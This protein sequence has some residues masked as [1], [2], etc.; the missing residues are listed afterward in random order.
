MRPIVLKVG[1]LAGA[2]V[3]NIGL[4]QS[5]AGAGWLALNGTLGTATANSIALSQSLAGAGAVL[6]NGAVGDKPIVQ[7][8]GK[9][10]I[11]ATPSRIYITSAGND[12]GIT[13]AVVGLTANGTG[14]SETITGANVG[15]AVSA[16]LYTTIISITASGATAAAITVGS[17]G[18]ATLD[19]PRRVLITTASAISFTIS[20]TNVSGDPISETV[21]NSGASVASVLDYATV[22]SISNSAAGTTITVGTNGVAASPWA[23][24]DEYTFA[25]VGLQCTVSGTANYTVQQSYDDPNL[26]V[27]PAAPSAMT[28]LSSNDTVVV[29][30]SASQVSLFASPPLWVRTLLNSGSGSVTTTVAQYASP[31][32]GPS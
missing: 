8:S 22:T 24:M 10:A 6:L 29:A 4:S 1:P 7:T 18:A 19:L 16:N 30:A 28:W 13:F 11:L 23:R 15:V 12:G 14:V 25:P 27:N 2:S 3:N 31:A 20:G 17:F 32:G 26:L 21:T 9:G 5:P